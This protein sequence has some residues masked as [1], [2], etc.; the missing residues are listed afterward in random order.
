M[1]K[2]LFIFLLSGIYFG[3]NAQNKIN[4][5][6][7]DKNTNEEILIGY[8]NKDGLTSPPFDEW[9]LA[10]YE[11]YMIDKESLEPVM[12]KVDKDLKIVVVLGTWCSDSQREVPRFMKI[13]SFLKIDPGQISIIAVDRSK[14]A[15]NIPLTDLNI[16]FVPTF[17]F[18]DHEKEIG[19]IVEWP[20]ESLE[21]DIE[22]IFA[23]I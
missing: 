7:L 9:F 16:E 20:E 19:R 18:Y 1:K 6:M 12:H 5:T 3:S 10:E 23:K 17:I 11:S 8:C 14:E 21:K 22:K 15:K 13:L 2:L 4:E